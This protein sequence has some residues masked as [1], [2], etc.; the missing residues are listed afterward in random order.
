MNNQK[1]HSDVV[2]YVCEVIN[3]VTGIGFVAIYDREEGFDADTEFRWVIVC[4]KHSTMT[5]AA[6]L[7]LAKEIMGCV[8][9]CQECQQ[10]QHLANYPIEVM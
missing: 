9:F 1:P 4:E 6:T 8:D 10:S 7:K 2:G 5:S 3:P